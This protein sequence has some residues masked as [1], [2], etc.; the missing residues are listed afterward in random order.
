MT[1]SNGEHRILFCYYNPESVSYFLVTGVGKSGR[2]FGYRFESSFGKGSS[3]RLV[4]EPFLVDEAADT[5]ELR[6]DFVELQPPK[7]RSVE[8][9]F[10]SSGVSIEAAPVS[11]PAGKHENPLDGNEMAVAGEFIPQEQLKAMLELCKGG[12][13]DR[14]IRKVRDVLAAKGSAPVVGS[15]GSAGVHRAML[16]YTRPSGTE[17][18]VCEIGDGINYGD[19]SVS[20][21]QVRNGD[22]KASGFCELSI[23]EILSAPGTELDFDF[24]AGMPVEEWLYKESPENFPQYAGFAVTDVR[25]EGPVTETFLSQDA[26]K[27]RQEASATVPEDKP[28]VSAQNSSSEHESPLTKEEMIAARK[29]IPAEQFQIIL[30][31]IGRDLNSFFSSGD[32]DYYIPKI[33]QLLKTVSEAPSTDVTD[34]NGEPRI[35]L[36]YSRSKGG[37]FFVTG[38]KD[39][40]PF[41]YVRKFSSSTLVSLSPTFESIVSSRGME[42]DFSYVGAEKYVRMAGGNVEVAPSVPA[43]TAEVSQDTGNVGAVQAPL[44]AEEQILVLNGRRTEKFRDGTT[45]FSWPDGRVI[46]RD[47]KRNVIYDSVFENQVAPADKPSGSGNQPP[48]ASS[49]QEPAR[50][51]GEARWHKVT[52]GEAVRIRD[53]AREI[54]SKED[55]DITPS[56]LE[57]LRAYEGAGGLHE[58]GQTAD[59]VLNE[60]YTPEFL[61]GKVAELVRSYKPDIKTALEPAAG[62]GRFADPFPG[63]RFTMYERDATSARINR[64]LH[65]DANIVNKE[66]QAQFFDGSGMVLNKNYV[67]PEYDLVIG[68]PPYGVY[69]DLF[70][71]R[72][73]GKEFGRYEEYFVSRG[74]DSLA[75]GGILAMVLPSSFLNS[76]VD[77]NKKKIAAKCEVVDA[78]RL[79]EGVFPSTDVGTDIVI[80]RRGSCAPEDISG[81]NYFVRNP[82]KICGS[83]RERLNR[84]K[85]SETYVACRDGE[86][87]YDA[88]MS[89]KA[90][91]SRTAV[92]P[93]AVAEP[94]PAVE[95]VPVSRT[96]IRPAAVAEPVPAVEKVRAPDAG[97][98]DSPLP[99]PGSLAGELPGQEDKVAELAGKRKLRMFEDKEGLFL[100]ERKLTAEEFA[101]AY[102]DKGIDPEE[103]LLVRATLW[104]GR[105]DLGLL[106]SGEEREKAE[107]YLRTSRKYVF[108]GTE[109][110]KPYYQNAVWYASGD[111]YEKMDKLEE[112]HA[113]ERI[114]DEDY[115][116]NLAFLKAVLP[117][118]RAISQIEISPI[119]PLAA[120]ID[121]G[122]DVCGLAYPGEEGDA[123]GL[124]THRER[125]PLKD[126]FLHWATGDCSRENALSGGNSPSAIYD[127][128][129]AGV[130]QKEIPSGITWGDIYN[131]VRKVPVRKNPGLDGDVAEIER[132]QKEDKRRFTAERLFNRF[133]REGLSEEDRKRVAH[134]WNRRFNSRVNAD[135]LDL[136]FFVDGMSTFRNGKPFMLYKQQIRG[137][138]F[139]VHKGTGLLAYDVGL[140]KTSCG[141][142]ATVSNM[143]AGRCS[144]PIIFVPLSVYANWIDT[145]KAHFPG[146][147]FLSFGNM[148]KKYPDFAGCYDPEKHSLNIEEGTVCFATYQALDVIV[149]RPESWDDVAAKNAGLPE[150]PLAEEF[151]RLFP[152]NNRGRKA[153]TEKSVETILGTVTMSAKTDYVVW[154]DSG[155]DHVTVDEAH[156]FKNLYGAPSPDDTRVSSPWGQTSNE[157]AG[158][159]Q[160]DSSRMALKMFAI[161]QLLQREKERNVF[162][163]TA[164]PFV[165]N[166]VEIYTMLSYVARPALVAA[167][168]ERL[169]DFC[170]EFANCK[171]QWGVDSSG[172]P[173]MK[174]VMKDF[175]NPGALHSLISE[176]IDK[177]GAEEAGIVRPSKFEFPSKQMDDLGVSRL[178]VE[179]AMSDVQKVVTDF[180][181]H[182][183]ATADKR[184]AATLVAMGNMRKALLSPAFFNPSDYPDAGIPDKAGFVSSSPKLRLVCD[185]AYR[186]WKAMPE[187]GQIIYMPT[188]EAFFPRLVAYFEA[189]GVPPGVVGEIK[190]AT[191]SEKRPKIRDAF[192]DPKNKMKIL[193]GTS[194]MSEGMDLNGN[195]VVLYLTQLDWNPSARVQVVGRIWRQG[196]LQD[197]V[198]VVIPY[199][200]NSIDSVFLQKYDEKSSRI[201]SV[202][203]Y[204]EGQAMDLSDISPEELKFDLITDPEVKARFVIDRKVQEISGEK[205]NLEGRVVSLY[206][207]FRQR[208]SKFDDVI[209]GTD[210]MENCR[211]R[212]DELVAGGYDRKDASVR[213]Q[214]EEASK[215]REFVRR[216]TKAVRDTDEKFKGEFDLEVTP[217]SDLSSP[218]RMPSG[219]SSVLTEDLMSG[220]PNLTFTRAEK[221]GRGNPR[222]VEFVTRD[223][224]DT[225]VS[226][227]VSEESCRKAVG[228]LTELFKGIDDCEL[229]I[230]AA[231]NSFASEVEKFREEARKLEEEAPS[232]DI[233]SRAVSLSDF[234]ISHSVYKDV[235]RDLP[236]A[237]REEAKEVSSVIADKEARPS[238]MRVVAGGQDAGVGFVVSE[239]V[240][241]KDVISVSGPDTVSVPVD[242]DVPV[243]EY[244]QL[245][246]FGALAEPVLAAGER[247]G[248]G[249]SQVS[250]E[251]GVSR[252]DDSPVAAAPAVQEGMSFEA[253]SALVHG[254]HDSSG[255]SSSDGGHFKEDYDGLPGDWK[256]RVDKALAL[257]SEAE[258]KVDE[259]GEDGNVSGDDYA[260]FVNDGIRKAFEAGAGNEVVSRD[261]ASAS[262]A[263]DAAPAVLMENDS[264]APGSLVNLM[265]RLDE[266]GND[267]RMTASGRQLKEILGYARG[268]DGVSKAVSTGFVAGERGISGLC[269]AWS[270]AAYHLGY[271]NTKNS[272]FQKE[273]YQDAPDRYRRAVW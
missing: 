47:A 34:S 255:H 36:V 170:V 116:R 11:V 26:Q 239:P 221:D 167:G 248:T 178:F 262:P 85:Q 6:F 62:P 213:A 174:R 58:G 105:I 19:M 188:G 145:F 59:G 92:R 77:G 154:E 260:A 261:A 41:G 196:N 51:G 249:V 264:L 142:V 254:L 17:I 119:S 64:L 179:Y 98:L 215:N 81:G 229:R 184:S 185:T 104:D 61:V 134:E 224:V 253:F 113:G 84:Y 246:L 233:V 168:V 252:Q 146:Q 251:Q 4:R 228:L 231:E 106:S 206:G 203:D 66:F 256:A 78:Y 182:R 220:L 30:G 16:R 157:F 46:K 63:V 232:V 273:P 159:A 143:Q 149:F 90:P 150:A 263:A 18:L 245:D 75:D 197:N 247:S 52:R 210:D 207:Y 114:G 141:I 14:Y 250:P 101:R 140:G 200:R 80:L 222:N 35:L 126:A 43:G 122:V 164:T 195:S 171:T 10:R 199:A 192:N 67:L 56:E 147:K 211:R 82:E 24:K 204:K 202:F 74:L 244:G 83:V 128:T 138:S 76:P 69:S 37:A 20:G 208:G 212:A 127:W 144:R 223:V 31:K 271:W 190:G 93:A 241:E 165:N 237:V 258:A 132:R 1:D 235:S 103:S 72:G 54:L 217:Y 201:N 266:I 173:A 39:G 12:D 71:G 226:S 5:T 162:F 243:D 22:F 236:A 100:S 166:P 158:I 73:E 205:K 175:K 42:L 118:P 45:V 238:D 257:V 107:R 225:I 189:L 2:P 94:V 86:T 79:P 25:Q 209:V 234:I 44:S 180:E 60:F 110:G 161:T 169:Y 91:V 216:K 97:L 40:N 70:K 219:E 135:Y 38:V 269:V 57:E 7:D 155:F 112:A 13:G 153:K 23:P 8:G 267:G 163:L 198:F 99:E 117:E 131:F 48:A 21:Y 89:I 214:L 125:M 137:V 32:W 108:M 115:R 130:S 9:F 102:S 265:R 160:V 139:L 95:K 194:A 176:Y 183:M 186:V 151:G 272:L 136:P 152:K 33:R 111:I 187:R 193:I 172:R 230:K 53:R 148:R 96:A 28:V 270:S 177:V 29:Y 121:V 191:P 87:P 181:K 55:K 65:P 50:E 240:E 49:S 68:N 129:V 3:V 227:G 259:Y 268:L 123:E 124:V 156:N 109:G 218:R 27:S 15:S 88:V 120:D 133:L 242:G